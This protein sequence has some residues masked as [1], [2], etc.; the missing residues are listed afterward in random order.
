MWGQTGH[1]EKG[2][3]AL[4]GEPQEGALRAVE[5]SPARR[6]E[7]GGRAAPTK[8]PPSPALKPESRARKPFTQTLKRSAYFAIVDVW[9]CTIHDHLIILLF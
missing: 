1:L 2:H 4:Q 7:R 5:A 6:K 9:E 8:V 3:P